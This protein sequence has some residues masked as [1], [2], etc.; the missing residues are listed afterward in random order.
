[1]ISKLIIA[2]GNPGNKYQLSRHNAAWLL[3]DE[4]LKGETW[5]NEKKFKALVCQKS[6]TL[7]LKPLSF[8][9]LSG[10]SVISALSYYQLIPKKLKFFTRKNSDL[11]EVLM[12]IH[13]DLDI[14]LGDY[15]LSVNRGSA[16]H[17]GV[18]SII[19]KTAT[20]NFSRI[21]LGIKTDTL[22]NIIPAEKFVMQNFSPEELK[23]LLS[24]VNLIKES[25]LK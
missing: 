4:M 23:L 19:E 7:F 11:S 9:N 22:K 1:M 14:N 8:M 20:K 6:T 16:G 2:L 3:L 12:V 18:N 15:K 25:C 24:N 17:K 21:R 5:Q 13:D 10:E